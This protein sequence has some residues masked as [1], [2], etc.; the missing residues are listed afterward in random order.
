MVHFYVEVNV[1]LRV[2]VVM[3]I[4]KFG[5]WVWKKFVV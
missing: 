1:G 4:D 5:L 2:V 3:D